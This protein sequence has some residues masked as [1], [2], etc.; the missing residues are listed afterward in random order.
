MGFWRKIIYWT[1]GIKGE[2]NRH[3]DEQQ[4]I[5]NNLHQAGIEEAELKRKIL[6]NN[7]PASMTIQIS[8]VPM[9]SKYSTRLFIGIQPETISWMEC[10]F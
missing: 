7:Q 10:L 3:N 9:A 4:S 2:I 5:Q 6:I 1:N 8:G